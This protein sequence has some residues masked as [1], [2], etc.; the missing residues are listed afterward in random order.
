M[1]R[2]AV[3]IENDRPDGEQRNPKALRVINALFRAVSNKYVVWRNAMEHR[4]TFMLHFVISTTLMGVCVTAALTAGYD[5]GRPI[6]LA[7]LAGF[8]VA[9][10][11]SWLVAR[12]I[13]H[14]VKS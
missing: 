8:I 4:L 12:K 14:L 7:A 3:S 6:A 11:I 9:L 2:L 5:T 10:P 1:L 13:T